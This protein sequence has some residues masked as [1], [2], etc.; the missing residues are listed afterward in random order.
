MTPQQSG[1]ATKED[2]PRHFLICSSP[3]RRAGPGRKRKFGLKVR[4]PDRR[5]RCAV[6]ADRS[7]PYRTLIRCLLDSRPFGLGCGMNAP[8]ALEKMCMLVRAMPLPAIVCRASFPA[9]CGIWPEGAVGLER[10]AHAPRIRVVQRD[11]G[12][13]IFLFGGAF[14]P[15]KLRGRIERSGSCR[16]RLQLVRSR[17][18]KIIDCHEAIPSCDHGLP[19]WICPRSF[20]ESWSRW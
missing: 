9:L 20:R 19:S 11:F 8:L 5:A 18:A 15:G 3:V 13:G 2:W 17:N 14:V 7:R 10:P 1:A 4:Y 6:N 16:A 12:R